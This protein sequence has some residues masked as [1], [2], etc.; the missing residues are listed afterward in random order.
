MLY[1]YI[2]C[3]GDEEGKRRGEDSVLHI[4]YPYCSVS[5][6]MLEVKGH[7]SPQGTIDAVSTEQDV[8]VAPK[9]LVVDFLQFLLSTVGIEIVGD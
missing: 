7:H 3:G 9:L 8:G 6:L 2:L 5:S 1:M 4:T